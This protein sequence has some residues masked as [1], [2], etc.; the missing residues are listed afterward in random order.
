MA[1]G[2]FHCWDPYPDA[3]TLED[4]H[5]IV[6]DMWEEQHRRGFAT[7]NEHLRAIIYHINLYDIQS[8]IFNT[9]T[10][11]T[12]RSAAGL[13]SGTKIEILPYFMPLLN[14]PTAEVILLV[15]RVI[16]VVWHS[17]LTIATLFKRKNFN[18]LISE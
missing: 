1:K 8:G 6:L 4:Q 13:L 5:K 12:E 14:L 7:E 15:L 16:L 3:P 17:V 10:V 11:V 9:I 2:H 18:A